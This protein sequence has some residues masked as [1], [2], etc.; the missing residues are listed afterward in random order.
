MHATQPSEAH[1]MNHGTNEQ[2]ALLEIN[3][4]ADP[5][6]PR[7]PGSPS[8]LTRSSEAGLD[9]NAKHTRTRAAKNPL[10]LLAGTFRVTM[11][12]T[13][14]LLCGL[15]A[16]DSEDSPAQLRRFIGQQVGGIDKLKV[17]ATDAAIPVPR[18]PDGSVN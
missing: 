5:A 1:E 18:Q 4:E 11:A 9:R 15:V 14:T 12:A 13:L 16:A 6:T 17:P 10:R 7:L 8:G 3:R 2:R